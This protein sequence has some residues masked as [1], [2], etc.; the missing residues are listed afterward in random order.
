LKNTPI[1]EN[2]LLEINEEKFFN[3]KGK[4]EISAFLKSFKFQ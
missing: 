2:I 3:L 1:I 4:K